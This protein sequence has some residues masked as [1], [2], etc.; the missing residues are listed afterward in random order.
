MG[1]KKQTVEELLERAIVSKEEQLYETPENWVC[2]RTEYI[3]EIVTGSTPSKKKEEYY[4]GNFPFIKPG[5]LMQKNNVAEATEYLSEEGKKVARVI[6]QGSTLIC[7]IG[8]IG[9]AGFSMV[10]C[11]TNQQI[12]SLI[13]N[14][15]L[16]SPKFAYYQVLNV[17]YQRELT[18]RSSATTVSI[19]NKSK[20]SEIPFLLPPLSEQK[21]IAMKVERLLE[22]VEEAK[23]LIEEAKET[24]NLRRAAILDKA[25]RGELNCN[26]YKQNS[27]KEY[28][29]EIPGNWVWEKFDDVAKVCSNLVDPKLYEQ[30]PHIAP[31][32]IGKGTGSLLEYKTIG[33]SKVKSSKHY[34]Y[35]GQILYSKIRPYLSKAVIA[36]FEGLC[37][38]DMY[39]I[40]TI[41]NTKYLF[42]YMLSPVFTEQASTAGSRSVL[43][44]I[45]KKELG[46][47]FIP[48]PPEHIQEEIVSFIEKALQEESVTKGL[49]ENALEKVEQTKQSV[50]SKAFRGELGTND[51]TEES[52]LE[53]LKEVLQEK[54]K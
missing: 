43:P 11:T 40:E 23:A 36:E 26:V 24:F 1:K 30:L 39:P 53:L 15:L 21:R 44:K 20:V 19:I 2:V 51:S 9:K 35:E 49:L 18:S 4:G 25:F 45:N 47:I 5:D 3:G 48:V 8:S 32:N 31:D 16:V 50:L 33:E 10:E 34:F 22:K 41:L 38:A 6:P 7:C 12:N 52:A 29:F 54:V 42:W 28:P 13:P 46:R 17:N 14:V 27:S 37:S